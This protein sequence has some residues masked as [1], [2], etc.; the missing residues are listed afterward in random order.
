MSAPPLRATTSSGGRSVSDVDPEQDEQFKQ[1]LREKIQGEMS[2]ARDTEMRELEAR[3]AAAKDDEEREAVKRD[4]EGTTLT[5]RRLAGEQFRELMNAERLRRK[6]KS[7]PSVK[8]ILVE[9]R[10]ILEQIQRS[11][12]KRSEVR[13]NGAETRP[14]DREHSSRQRTQDDASA[15]GGS[16]WMS[17]SFPHS[18]SFSMASSSSPAPIPIG[19]ADNIDS[20]TE[21]EVAHSF[22]A[23]VPVGHKHSSGSLSSTRS[24][25]GFWGERGSPND[26]SISS[27][28][29]GAATSPSAAVPS[30]RDSGNGIWKSGIASSIPR[31]SSPPPILAARRDSN[32]SVASSRSGPST[33]IPRPPMPRRDSDGRNH[34]PT[35]YASS[36][37][38]PPASP[39]AYS[40][41]GYPSSSTQPGL[42]PVKRDSGSSEFRSGLSA[43]APR[44]RS[45]MPPILSPSLPQPAL[46][47]LSKG[48]YHQHSERGEASLEPQKTGDD[49]SPTWSYGK[50]KDVQREDGYKSYALRHQSSASDFYTRRAETR[51][52]QSPI[53]ITSPTSTDYPRTPDSYRQHGPSYSAGSATRRF[54]PDDGIGIPIVRAA[55][56][57]AL[58]DAQSSPDWPK[59]SPA[60]SIGR[61]MGRKPSFDIEQ[62]ARNPSASPVQARM[63]YHD[64]S[65]GVRRR[66]SVGS[67]H[68]GRSSRSQSKRPEIP[69]R[70]ATEEWVAMPTYVEMPHDGGSDQSDIEDIGWALS[71]VEDNL[72]VRQEETVRKEA[73]LKQKE[74]EIKRKEEDAR[75]KEEQA[76]D[77][78]DE[79]R[80][81]EDAARRKEEE[82]RK[83][84][85]AAR[86]KEMDARRKEEEVLRKEEEA[87]KMT[88][89]ARKKEEDA[90]KL[91]EDARK[92]EE[93]ARKKE[94]DAR[95]IEEDARRIEEEARRREEEA[96][97]LEESLRQLEEDTRRRSSDLKRM[98]EDARRKEEE[99]R[100]REEDA[101]RKEEDARRKEEDARRKEE[102]ARRREEDARER[103][104]EAKQRVEEAKQRADEAKQRAE[105]ARLRED[106]LRQREEEVKQREEKLRIREE[107]FER[108]EA[109]IRRQEEEK[110][111]EEL[112]AEL[113][114]HDRKQ[115]DE[116]IAEQ[117]RIQAEL[118]AQRQTRQLAEELAERLQREEQQKAQ[119]LAEQEEIRRAEL[120]AQQE[121]QQ[122]ADALAEERRAAEA[123]A[124]EERKKAV[125]EEQRR[126]EAVAQQE[127]LRRQEDIRRQEQIAETR[128]RQEEARRLAEYHR[129]QE[130]AR[131]LQ[132]FARQ[133]EDLRRQAE[134]SARR[135]QENQGSNPDVP[136][137]NT[138]YSSA[139][140]PQYPYASSNR[141]STASTA[142]T[143]SSSSSWGTGASGAWSSKASSATSSQSA[144]AAA[145][146]WRSASTNPYATPE[147]AGAR[148][149]TDDDRE[150]AWRERQ[151]EQARKQAEAFQREQERVERE[152]QARAGKVMSKEDVLRLYEEHERQWLRIPTLDML[153]WATFA[154][155]MLKKPSSP[156]ELT[157]T[158][159]SA[160]VLNPYA[161]GDKSE[162]DRIK[163]HIRRWHPDRFE[164]KLLPRVRSDDRE[165]V[166]EGAGQVV[167]SLNELLTRSSS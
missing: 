126:A 119:A 93:D 24:G 99:A 81:K 164:T 53:P 72:R 109:D 10:D 47:E 160:Y 25:P 136:R 13:T 39:F 41:V 8:T 161:P 15:W 66:T 117:K 130:E 94:Q 12:G 162:K 56:P 5:W 3:L 21:E 37:P 14:T 44:R 26:L 140:P 155:P 48:E 165:K 87:R 90:R 118:L 143:A 17:T 16:P 92:K 46:P 148:R 97:R 128:R 59:H 113:A 88:I 145:G 89:E 135:R 77:K 105:E 9:Q 114:R 75:R 132:E 95:R 139:V 110:R 147:P 30:K 22:G 156:E 127:E 166:K 124:Q 137:T 63:W 131:R 83:K 29:Y 27:R 123:L 40:P 58:D 152:R 158:A 134:E 106:L 163:E 82:A 2:V 86:R 103:A 52:S 96:E 68:S 64:S 84:E 35:S 69:V 129:Q 122:K 138:P 121:E 34:P 7:D 144:R 116:V 78:E 100:K 79:A 159:I 133:Q 154:W 57:T 19:R 11:R 49:G 50:G 74:E 70:S 167:R 141:Q 153:S 23:H 62:R 43:T 28:A 67:Y 45:P 120:R 104:E 102:D 6:G 108:R 76:R 111:T 71:D 36:S 157:T 115:M 85:D 107:E 32:A 51:A 146:A 98:E 42:S 125:E 33:S 65:G 112:L 20:F 151:E 150:K 4:I 38:A 18:N 61:A 60:V 80:R 54:D 31:S 149:S 1:A 91:E 142:S 73:E 55:S 101:R